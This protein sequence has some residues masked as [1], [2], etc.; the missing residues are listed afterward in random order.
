MTIQEARTKILNELKDIY[1]KSEAMIIAELVLEKIIGV[2]RSEHI[3]HKEVFLSPE[4]IEELKKILVRLKQNEPV[5][6]A[7]EEAWFAGMKFKVNK[8]VLIPR[9]ETEELVEWIVKEIRSRKS[10]VGKI[11][12]IGTG[13]G[14]IATAI[15]KKLPEVKVSAIDIS[16]EA[17]LMAK[18]NAL[19]LETDINFILLDFLDEIKWNELGKYDVVVSNP[20][21]VKQMEKETMHM[22]VTAHEPRLA[23][24]V[25]D[26]DALLFYRKLADFSLSHLSPNGNLFVEINESLGKEVAELFQKK[27]FK[28]VELKKDMQGKERMVRAVLSPEF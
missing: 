7:L 13:S 21:Y 25:P 19:T 14:C 23:L 24:F 26:N 2:E 16:S 6:Y 1:D 12:D 27:G 17:L 10:E 28:S 15:K 22:R 8:N 20:P 9:P 3:L 11:L 18:E 4:Q 5:Q